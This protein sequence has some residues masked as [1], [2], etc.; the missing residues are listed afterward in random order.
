MLQPEAPR[1][2]LVRLDTIVRSNYEYFSGQAV[3]LIEL[4]QEQEEPVQIIIMVFL[5]LNLKKIN[6]QRKQGLA[7]SDSL[8]QQICEELLER[9]TPVIISQLK[10]LPGDSM[11]NVAKRLIGIIFS[12]STL[13]EHAI[14]LMIVIEKIVLTPIAPLTPVI[15]TCW[16]VPE[17][18]Q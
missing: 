5:A 7:I 1:E 13:E 14:A 11:A 9:M 10:E 15:T 12:F 3:K 17:G 8:S 4:L 2:V 18:I 16:K 6:K